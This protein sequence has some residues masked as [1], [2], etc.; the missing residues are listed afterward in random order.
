MAILGCKEAAVSVGFEEVKQ[1]DWP[2]KVYRP[3]ILNR[4]DT[5][6]RKPGYNPFE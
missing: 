6:Y 2:E 1:E 4:P 5:L 3:D